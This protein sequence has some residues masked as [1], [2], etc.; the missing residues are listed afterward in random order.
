MINPVQAETTSDGANVDALVDQWI[1]SYDVTV[2]AKSYCPYCKHTEKIMHEMEASHN[3]GGSSAVNALGVRFVYLDR[4]VEDDGPLIQMELLTKTGQ[5]TVP[6]IFIGGRHIGGDSDL[7]KLYNSG[8]LT[9]M[10]NR[11]VESKIKL[12][13]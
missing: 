6:N 2:F 8:E 11:L 10:L 12:T 9:T 5:K 7:T 4:M 1:S 3:G 13:K